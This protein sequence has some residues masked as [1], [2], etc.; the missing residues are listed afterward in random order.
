MCCSYDRLVAQGGSHA[1]VLQ[2]TLPRQLQ[3]LLDRLQRQTQHN[4]TPASSPQAV[5]QCSSPTCCSE[6]PHELLV[7]VL[8]HVELPLRLGPCSLVCSAWQAAAAAATSSV[9]LRTHT[10]GYAATSQAGWQ[11]DVTLRVQDI[12]QSTQV[13][14][15][16][17]EWLA[18][19][20]AVTQLSVEHSGSWCSSSQPQLQLPWDQLLQLQSLSCRNVQL[21][22][23]QQPH[24]SSCSSVGMHQPQHN[25]Q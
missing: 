13:L 2:G 20:A 4:A 14:Q 19:H 10:P 18:K 5:Q 21:L 3:Q 6:L 23:Q 25:Q 11:A 15:G 7:R 12:E 24:N 1:S 17:S 9:A 8:Q 22:Q 16:G